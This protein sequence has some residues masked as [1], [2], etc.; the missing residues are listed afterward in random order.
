MEAVA[1]LKVP[2]LAEAKYGKSWYDAK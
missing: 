2:L 1:C